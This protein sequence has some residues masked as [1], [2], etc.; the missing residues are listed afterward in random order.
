MLSEIDELITE[1]YLPF[2][3]VGGATEKKCA[4][5]LDAVE[6]IRG[7]WAKSCIDRGFSNFLYGFC[8]IRST[9]CHV[10]GESVMS[11][12]IFNKLWL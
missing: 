11:F 3:Y 9:S 12:V 1:Q 7:L 2:C 8:K 10:A 6:R 4:A 5:V